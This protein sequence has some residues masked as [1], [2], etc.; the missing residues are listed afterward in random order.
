MGRALLHEIE[1]HEG[2]QLVCA[3]T[4][5]ESANTGAP[6]GPTV[7]SADVGAALQNCDALIDFSH[8]KAAIDAALLM[9]ST[10]CK[11]LVTGTT[12]YSETEEEALIA[13]AS[14]IT[15]VKSG[16]F[17]VGIC[18]LE[19]LVEIAARTL[20]NTDWDA[21][22]LDIHHRHKIDAPSGTALMLGHAVERGQNASG[23]SGGNVPKIEYAAQRIGGV[24]GVHHVSLAS[25]LETLTLSHSAN[26]RS[27]FAA[28]ALTAA[29]WAIGQPNG[30]Y[31]MQDVLGL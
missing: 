4:S 14:Q 5:L 17:S 25:E 6:Y 29:L 13:S 2:A 9:H 23:R 15:L 30:L 8:P 20:N 26:D 11:T 24:I 3:L 19:S 28:G 22:I 1:K 31:T 16:N 21:S 18:L 12:G 7:L 27:V 10:P